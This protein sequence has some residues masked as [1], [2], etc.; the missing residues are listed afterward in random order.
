MLPRG[1]TPL[2][3]TK[4]K[5]WTLAASNNYDEEGMTCPT[6]E[7]HDLHDDIARCMI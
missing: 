1:L 4:K 6:E 7:K 2:P 3:K 5:S